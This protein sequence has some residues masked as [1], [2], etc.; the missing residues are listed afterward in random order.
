MELYKFSKKKYKKYKKIIF[1]LNSIKINKFNISIK[2]SLYFKFLTHL[3]FQY[4]SLAAQLVF[5][6][7]L[8]NKTKV[9]SKKYLFIVKK[10][11]KLFLANII[12]KKKKV[13]EPTENEIKSFRNTSTVIRFI[14]TILKKIILNKN[15]CCY[16][17]YFKIKKFN[18][19]SKKRSKIKTFYID[20]IIFKLMIVL[21]KI[22]KEVLLINFKVKSLCNKTHSKRNLKM[23]K[24]RRI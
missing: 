22:C 11:E 8:K 18:K 21:H 19:E 10:N 17:L 16:T 4:Y 2:N 12:Y 20:S 3:N 5:K 6:N 24:I 14:N 9:K 13:F 1:F 15:F 7:K 23:K